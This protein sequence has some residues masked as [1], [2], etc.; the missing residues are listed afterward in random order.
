MEEHAETCLD[1][2]V[3]SRRKRR[4]RKTTTEAITFW[5][6]PDVQS[7]MDAMTLDNDNGT[8]SGRGLTLQFRQWCRV[9]QR[10]PMVWRELECGMGRLSL[11]G[12]LSGSLAELET[13]MKLLM[14]FALRLFPQEEQIRPTPR[15]TP[16]EVEGNP[17][18]GLS[19]V[20]HSLGCVIF[21]Y[22]ADC[23]V[24]ASESHLLDEALD[25]VVEHLR[26]LAPLANLDCH[27]PRS[28]CTRQ[29]HSSLRVTNLRPTQ[30]DGLLC[31]FTHLTACLMGAVVGSPPA[32]D[33]T[34]RSLL[35]V[36]PRVNVLLRVDI[37]PGQLF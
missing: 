36:W 20:D 13:Q 10:A 31:L 33:F 28:C 1:K 29:D 7:F 25:S 30:V 17:D 22:Q 34:C 21:L 5:L 27:L 26:Y 12:D 2:T 9:K 14:G 32:L 8:A 15:Y 6:D 11:R 19:C 24:P 37:D 4:S 3:S 16:E 18:V 35:R 23:M